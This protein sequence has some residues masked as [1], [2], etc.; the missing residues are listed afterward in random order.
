MK[1]RRT[2]DRIAAAL[3]RQRKA[4]NEPRRVKTMTPQILKGDVFQVLQG[5]AIAAGSVDCVVTSPPY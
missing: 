5:G 2:R 4:Q 1:Q 3:E